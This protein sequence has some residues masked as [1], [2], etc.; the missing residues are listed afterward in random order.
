MGIRW[1]CVSGGEGRYKIRIGKS[2]KKIFWGEFK[3]DKQS[4]LVLL[5]SDG[6]LIGGGITIT[7]IKALYIDQLLGLLIEGDIFM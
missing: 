3:F 2:I 6:S 4:L 1:I 5:I 7:V